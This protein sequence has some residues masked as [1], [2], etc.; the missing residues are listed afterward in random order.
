MRRMVQ[1]LARNQ[2]AL[3]RIKGVRMIGSL[4]FT[5]SGRRQTGV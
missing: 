2:H 1:D 4:S 5:S 3:A